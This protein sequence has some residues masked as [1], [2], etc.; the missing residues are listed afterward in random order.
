MLASLDV[1]Q[2]PGRFAFV[3]GDYP[4]LRPIAHAVV[5][6]AEGITYVVQLAV[7]LA[8]CGELD[9]AVAAFDTYRTR[10]PGS[11]DD[12]WIGAFLDWRNRPPGRI[13]R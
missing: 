12:A 1:E 13:R 6:E 2:R 3:T 5:C 9:E 4:A 10:V 7:A 11:D 8:E